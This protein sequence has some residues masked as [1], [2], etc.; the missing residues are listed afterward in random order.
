L[1]AASATRA[2]HAPLIPSPD[3]AAV[4]QSWRGGAHYFRAAY[5]QHLIEDYNT[6]GNAESLNA[7]LEHVEP[8]A[9]SILEYRCTTR[10]E[11]IDELLS[12]IRIKLWKSVE[13][14]DPARG[15]AFSFVSMVI[16][17]VAMTAVNESWGRQ[18][19]FL[20]LE[21]ADRCAA[22]SETCTAEAI[23]DIE[24]RVRLIKTPCTDPYE[25]AAQRWL[26]ESFV[27]CSFCIRRHQAADSMS[28]VFGIDYR[29]SR[30]LFDMSL[31]GVRSS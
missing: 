3:Q 31:I 24:A 26:I 30:W 13:L 7:L 27:D 14:F 6:N 29:R 15:S 12:R 2:M 1:P 18:G 19:R 9:R 21:E 10:H 5:A 20:A 11:G 4:V 8:L 28:E 25:L 22:P 16:S 17:R 23:A